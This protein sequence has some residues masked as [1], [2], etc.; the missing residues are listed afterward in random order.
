MTAGGGPEEF[1]IRSWR[2]AATPV[3]A[4]ARDRWCEVSMHGPA[5]AVPAAALAHV[6]F[7]DA[8]GWPA[9]GRLHLRQTTRRGVCFVPPGARSARLEVVGVQRR[10]GNA[11]L[12]FRPTGTAR[13]AVRLLAAHPGIAARLAGEIAPV[14]PRLELAKARLRHGLARAIAAEQPPGDYRLWFSFFG[15][16]LLAQVAD[17]RG[18]DLGHGRVSPGGGGARPGGGAPY[19]SF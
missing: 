17:H 10:P 9:G 2:F 7:L 14:L 11:A 16:G 6:D 19:V 5:A 12:S 15:A 4:E 8:A 1:G 13:A 18:G 3:P